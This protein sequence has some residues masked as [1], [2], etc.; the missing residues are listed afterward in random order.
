MSAELWFAI[1]SLALGF[2][3]ACF[4][5]LASII[6]YFV[7][8]GED[9]Q[10][11][12]IAALSAEQNVLGQ[13]VAA[14]KVTLGKYEMHIGAGDARLAE[15]RESIADHVIKEEQIFWKK[16]DAISDAQRAF[17]E[18]VLQRITSME[19]KL[20]NGE[21]QKMALD[22]AKLVERFERV[23]GVARDAK[24]STDSNVKRLESLEERV[25]EQDDSDT[26][27][28]RRTRK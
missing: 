17:A 21:L 6:A 25:R 9:A 28:R 1:V 19:S 14:I 15:I 4:S 10:D 8:R 16:V 5:A 13:D 2:V 27:L 18:A 12:T 3:G 26:R 7:K 22:L 24:T 11:K 23:E 20:P